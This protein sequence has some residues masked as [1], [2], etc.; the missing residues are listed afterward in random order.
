MKKETWQEL[1]KKALTAI[2]FYLADEVLDEFSTEKTSSSLWERI[3]DHYLKKSLANRL[4]LKQ[5][6]FL[7]CMHEGTPFKS[8]IAEFFSI[9]NDLDEIEIKIE[10]ENQALLLLCSLSSS[11]KSFKED[12]IYG[13]KSTIKVNEVK[14]HLLNTDK[15]DT[16]DR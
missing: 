1:D 15:I 3:K 13:G 5:Y 10:D 11:Y 6:L 8:Y 9:I 14:E 4:I 2:Q 12:I 7:L 16:V